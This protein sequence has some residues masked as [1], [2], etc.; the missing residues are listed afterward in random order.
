MKK[1]I[2]TVVAFFLVFSTGALCMSVIKPLMLVENG[3]AKGRIVISETPDEIGYLGSRWGGTALDRTKTTRYAAELLQGYIEKATGTKLEIVT[4]KKVGRNETVIC[5]GRSGLTDFVEKERKGLPPEGFIIRRRGNVVAIVG[6]IASGDIPQHEGADRGTLWGV[7]EFLEQACGIRWYFPHE[8]GTVIPK[9]GTLSVGKMDIKKHPFY[10]MRTGAIYHSE[11]DITVEDLLPV[12]RHGNTTGFSANHTH[13]GWE[14]MYGDKYPDIFALDPDGESTLKKSPLKKGE[15]PSRYNRVCYS[16]P[17]ILKLELQHIRDYCEKGTTDPWRYGSARPFHNYI[18]VVPK[19]LEN[20][21]HCR[22]DRCKSRWVEGLENSKLTELVFGY[23]A[24]VAEET[25]KICPEKRIATLAYCGFLFPPAKTDIP[26]NLDVM[27]CTVKGGSKLSAPGHW[28]HNVDLVNQWHERV[29]GN[30]SRLFLFEYMVYPSVQAPDF[31][32]GTLQKWFRFLKG[33]V[34]GGFN[35]AANPRTLI[36]YRF[37]LFNGWLWH[38]LMWDPDLNMNALMEDYYKNLFGPAEKPMKE[39]F[40]LCIERWENAPWGQ[41]LNPGSVSYVHDRFLY[42]DIYPADV[43]EKMQD[44]LS[45]ARES[46]G[47]ESIYRRRVEYFGEAFELFF[48]NAKNFYSA[49]ASCPEYRARFVKNPDDEKGSVN[50]EIWRTVEPLNLK[51]WRMGE[52]PPCR[53]SVKML[54]DGKRLYI[55]VEAEG[56]K[57]DSL[58]AKCKEEEAQSIFNDDRI[59]IDFDLRKKIYLQPEAFYKIVFNSS[60]K[61]AS[62]TKV[63]PFVSGGF[64]MTAW[65]EFWHP[66][67]MKYAVERGENSWSI[68]TA[69]PFGAFP[70]A[71]KRRMEKIRM[72]IVRRNISAP[73]GTFVWSPMVSETYEYPLERFGTVILETG[74]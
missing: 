23:I 13:L 19:D 7:F 10:H 56:Q 72:Q 71:E 52:E 65:N 24:K 55:R 38:K 8:L 47:K 28:Q 15:K 64:H 11:Q 35:N 73:R 2:A 62:G 27:I 42:R 69:I 6:E 18:P 31:C 32:P 51:G 49:D 30:P 4:D 29:D 12:T 16:N 21:F 26:D 74:N 46:A 59:E 43:I 33:K 66:S 3:A 54:N 39:L 5:V 48:A 53:T 20:I 44:L 60:G 1:Y 58:I 57:T 61:T 45:K 22:C 25:K 17:K 50:P 9:R 63:V 36:R 67:G 68:E 34:S 70:E 40:N 41:A 14:I 37:S